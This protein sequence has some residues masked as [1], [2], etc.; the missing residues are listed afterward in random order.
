MSKSHSAEKPLGILELRA[1][2]ARGYKPFKPEKMLS[3]SKDQP[4]EKLYGGFDLIQTPMNTDETMDMQPIVVERKKQGLS[5]CK[6]GQ[7]CDC[8]LNS[9]VYM[10]ILDSAEANFLW[11]DIKDRGLSLEHVR[12]IY[13]YYYH[14]RYNGSY[15]PSIYRLRFGVYPNTKLDS[16][17]QTLHNLL[18]EDHY[19]FI[20]GNRR[21]NYGHAFLVGKKNG[22][23]VFNDPQG[24]S[25]M[26]SYEGDRAKYN[27]F[28]Y[29]LQQYIELEILVQKD[30]GLEILRRARKPK[31]SQ[32]KTSKTRKRKRGQTPSLR[33]Q[34]GKSLP[35]LKKRKHKHDYGIFPETP[36][37]FHP[38]VRRKPNKKRKNAKKKTQKR[39][40]KK[41]NANK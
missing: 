5:T 41:E 21:E 33:R 20:A 36:G 8:V 35:S 7:A 15:L 14:K 19:T 22:K 9:L 23:L 32:R 27:Q 16:T 34:K 28:V 26:L 38:G 11:N 6:E 18:D 1:M 24:N 37:V 10:G 25:G 39:K 2:I 40:R 4:L 13:Y 12:Q 17:L 31:P 29:N 3:Y 30:V